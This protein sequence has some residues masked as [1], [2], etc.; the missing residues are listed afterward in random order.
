MNHY[1]KEKWKRKKIKWG[2]KGTLIKKGLAIAPIIEEL[3]YL[4][5]TN[6]YPPFKNVEGGVLEGEGK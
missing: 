6:N 5:E 3:S 1:T 4:R 2:E